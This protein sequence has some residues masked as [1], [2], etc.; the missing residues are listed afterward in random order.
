[1]TARTD[2]TA[3]KARRRRRRRRLLIL[4]LIGLSA[5]PSVVTSYISIN[6]FSERALLTTD[7]WAPMP[8]DVRAEPNL[9]IHATGMLP[10]DVR[11]GT[12]TV[13]NVG[14]DPL[15]YAL[16]SVSND[17]DRK[18]LRDVLVTDVRA[19]GSG[20]TAFDGAILYSGPLVG[21]GFGDPTGG[22]QAGDR[23]LAG[24]QQERICVRVELPISAGN[25]YQRS[26]T[27]TT[28]TVVAEHAA[29]TP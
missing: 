14:A 1:M 23:L 15:R 24:G 6:L 25:T 8:I 13:A 4:L 28:F 3:V 11:G 2:A 19:E 27:E 9:L 20:C 16:V 10:G 12:L 7:A 17:P 29:G 22:Q 5:V 26:L 18:G 21:A